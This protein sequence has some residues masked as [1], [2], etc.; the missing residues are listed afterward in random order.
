M[1]RAGEWTKGARVTQAERLARTEVLRTVISRLEETL[2]ELRA[3]QQKAL[4][5]CEHQYPD[6]R[7]ASTG[8]STKVCAICGQVLKGREGKLWG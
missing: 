3:E 8:A 1:L 7:Q 6:G 2:A 5:G 4:E